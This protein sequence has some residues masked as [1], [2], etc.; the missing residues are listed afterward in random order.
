MSQAHG[1][2]ATTDECLLIT[3]FFFPD[4]FCLQANLGYTCQLT[5]IFRTL[6][7]N[8]C[9]WALTLPRYVSTTLRFYSWMINEG[10]FQCRNDLGCY[11][12][13]FQQRVREASKSKVSTDSEQFFFKEKKKESEFN[14]LQLIF[15]FRISTVRRHDGKDLFSTKLVGVVPFNLTTIS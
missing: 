6:L 8:E 9:L 5:S 1:K 11:S 12:F 13:S 15:L 7:A 2:H 4:R 14:I 10:T 3:S